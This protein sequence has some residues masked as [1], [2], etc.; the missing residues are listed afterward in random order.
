MSATKTPKLTKEQR[1]RV[2]ELVKDEGESQAEAAA[3]V[4]AFEPKVELL[5]ADGRDLSAAAPG[6]VSR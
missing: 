6:P 1:A 2:Q 4:L 3:W 5:K